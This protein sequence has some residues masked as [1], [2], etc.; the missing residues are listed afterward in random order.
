M[1]IWGVLLISL[2]SAVDGFF[3]GLSFGFQKTRMRWTQLALLSVW[4]LPMAFLAL[5]G[6]RLVGQWLSDQTA[7]LAGGVI[8]V[9]AGLLSLWES[10]HSKEEQEPRESKRLIMVGVALAADG[11]AAAFSLGLWNA[12]PLLIPFLFAA[13]QLVLVWAGNRLGLRGSQK[14]SG[15][16]TQLLPAFILVLIGVLKLLPI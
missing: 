3:V 16:P 14:L 10:L 2:I 8:M 7:N 6:A 9:C 15:K 12:I 11:C 13:S 4:N 5:L 1:E